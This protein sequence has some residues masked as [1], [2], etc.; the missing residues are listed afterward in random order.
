MDLDSV[1]VSYE[2]TTLL[3]D[4]LKD[5]VQLHRTLVTLI[6]SL[7]EKTFE[8]TAVQTAFADAMKPMKGV[9]GARLKF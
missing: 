3:P 6:R 2:N 7:D 8:I 9:N 1:V 4:F 5:E